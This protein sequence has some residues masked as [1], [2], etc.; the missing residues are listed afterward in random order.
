MFH[1]WNWQ[2]P[3]NDDGDDD[4]DDDDAAAAAAAADDDD[5]DD[6]VL[7]RAVTQ[8]Y[9]TTRVQITRHYPTIWI[10]CTEAH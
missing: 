3:S 4:D 10:H 7:Y 6:V 2:S 9:C 8:C 5:D 1:H